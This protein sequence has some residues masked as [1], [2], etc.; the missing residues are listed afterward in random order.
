MANR[1]VNTPGFIPSS[2]PK[3]MSPQRQSG[4]RQER[5]SPNSS[6]TDKRNQ[7]QKD[8]K[9][10]CSASASDGSDSEA[11]LSDYTFDL[12]KLP[13]AGASGGKQEQHA[14][15]SSN[16]P[17]NDGNLSEPG[18]P[19]DFT[20]NMVE[21]LKGANAEDEQ[22]S[23]EE[24]RKQEDGIDEPIQSDQDEFSEIEPPLDMSTPAHFL[25][26]RDNF[27][28]H[29]MQLDK[30]GLLFELEQLR[31]ESRKK[32]E[33][34]NA[35]QRRVLD[36]A[37][38]VQQVRHLQS[39]LRT[40]NEKRLAELA[41]RDQHIKELESQLYAKD[42]QLKVNQIE[43]QELQHLRLDLDRL[44]Q[45]SERSGSKD[46]NTNI[47]ICSLREEVK[48]KDKLL[49]E[50][51][52]K[53]DETIACHQAQ[54]RER[55]VENDQLRL[56]R[57]RT[58][59]LG[60]PDDIESLARERD[61]LH[62]RT[63]DLDKIVQHLELQVTRLQHDLSTEKA[64]AASKDDALRKVANRMCLDADGKSFGQILESFEHAH[65][66][67]RHAAASE[68][69]ANETDARME[70]AEKELMEI[71][72]QLQEATSF[73]RIL[74]LE[75]ESAREELSES[76]PA[77]SA[78]RKANCQLSSQ[79]ESASTERAQLRRALEI[80]TQERNEAVHRLDDLLS[81]TMPQQLLSPAPSPPPCAPKNKT[82]HDFDSLQK[83][84]QQELNCIGN[85]HASEISTL[86]DTHAQSTRSLHALL[87][88]AQD[89]ESELQLELVE[90]RKSSI[91]KAQEL[92]IEQ[93]RLESVIE[94]KD[95]AAAAL[96]A[97]FASV[98]K[99]REEAWKSR[100]EKLQRDREKMG[101][102]L[103]WTWGEM[104]VGPAKQ[105]ADVQDTA[106]KPEY[107]QGYKYKYAERPKTAR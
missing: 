67:Q 75:L 84:H 104:E 101:K 96:D 9:R 71:R 6:R 100:I 30:D 13:N 28:S 33:I 79:L 81:K 60:R 44:R 3:M 55:A 21:L 85:L 87:R 20:L 57:E 10:R 69:H 82:Q 53:F 8:V 12:N 16:Q 14:I 47:E 95:A 66:G 5:F 32:D 26:R 35:N 83:S 64:E 90:L 46:E 42:G 80:M 89:R 18:G 36:A 7:V 27:P 31:K 4:L 61:I 49:Q 94:A 52:A 73:T 88:A 92:V 17:E 29:G 51:K 19:D 39:E 15:V 11:N 1:E 68:T 2:P 38:I 45:Q 58:C 77:L 23:R 65:Q 62:K 72:I 78:A 63:Q 48:A 74:S 99:K 22:D 93:E 98:L 103:M 107:T 91:S 54:L 50:A 24:Q 43:L 76:Q 97:K 70:K 59:K 106:A 102:V 40:E 37:S 56:E 25:S 86:R 34:I 105:R 41:S